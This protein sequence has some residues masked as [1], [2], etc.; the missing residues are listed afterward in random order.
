MPAEKFDFQNAQGQKLAAL[1]D[2]PDGPARAVA[3]FAHC[4][5]CGKDNRAARRI[6]EGLTLHGIAVLRFDFTG[7]GGSEG[8][9]AAT[10]F[11]SNIDDLVAEMGLATRRTGNFVTEYLKPIWPARYRDLTEERRIARRGDGD[12][13]APESPDITMEPKDGDVAE[14]IPTDVSLEAAKTGQ[15]RP[16]EPGSDETR[17]PTPA[18]SG[19]MRPPQF[20]AAEI[21]AP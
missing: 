12:A 16:P 3:L 7:L 17:M 1:L 2:R 15:F 21:A 6:A 8:E 13:P 4:F 10:T 11:T 5:T 19:Q 9:F 18:I 20:P 14:Y